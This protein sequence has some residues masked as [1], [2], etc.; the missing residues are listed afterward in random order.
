[1]CCCKV[2]LKFVP[3]PSSPVKQKY[4]LFLDI[5]CWQPGEPKHICW[6][7]HAVAKTKLRLTRKEKQHKKYGRIKAATGVGRG[8]GI[9]QDAQRFDPALRTVNE[10]QVCT[11]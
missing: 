1:M 4:M 10:R 11:V 5:L 6:L 2:A 3:G 8:D 7:D 9:M